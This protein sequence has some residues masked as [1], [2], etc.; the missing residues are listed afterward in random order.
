M[1]RYNH[2]NRVKSMAR[3]TPRELVVSNG[4]CY[5]RGSMC[6]NQCY[7]RIVDVSDIYLRTIFGISF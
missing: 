1:T 4:S 3:T 6:K 2:E 5:K 7:K